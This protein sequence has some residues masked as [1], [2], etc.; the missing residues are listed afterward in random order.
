MFVGVSVCGYVECTVCLTKVLYGYSV[1]GRHKMVADV[2]P[3]L[4][5]GSIT[6]LS[7]VS[8]ILIL[9]GIF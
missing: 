7:C 6:C 4:F 9:H 8:V 5:A 2:T 3:I 1:I